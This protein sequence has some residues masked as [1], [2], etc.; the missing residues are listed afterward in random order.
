[1]NRQLAINIVAFGVAGLI[2]GTNGMNI[3]TW[4]FWIILA[5]MVTVQTNNSLKD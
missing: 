4:Q 5:C 3:T 2:L 1:M